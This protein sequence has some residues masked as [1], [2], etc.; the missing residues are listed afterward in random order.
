MKWCNDN[1]ST[2]EDVAGL[3]S[4]PSN[5][6]PDSFDFST[7]SVSEKGISTSKLKPTDSTSLWIL[8]RLTSLSNSS[9]CKLSN[10]VSSM[11]KQLLSFEISKGETQC[12]ELVVLLSSC[13]VS[14]KPCDASSCSISSHVVITS[15]EVRLGAPSNSWSFKTNNFTTSLPSSSRFN[16]KLR[17]GHR[18][19]ISSV[20][21]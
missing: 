1:I 10:S 21:A 7:L 12:S 9:S 13:C 6:Q 11:P 3:P 2:S 15:N 18:L 14:S 8:Y 17:L 5:S 19:A 20:S 16:L 4:N